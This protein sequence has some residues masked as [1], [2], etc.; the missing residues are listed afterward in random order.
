MKPAAVAGSGSGSTRRAFTLLELLVVIVIVAVLASL[1]MPAYSR[2]QR[3]AEAVAC[4]ANLREIG[5]GLNL[6]LGEHQMIMPDL[7]ALRSKTTDD[8]AVIDNTLDKYVQNKAVFAC[9][10]DHLGVA[11]ASGTSYYWNST[12]NKQ[13]VSSLAF[14][15]L[16]EDHSRIPVLN[17]KQGFHPYLD[18]KI[19]I[20]YADGHV[21][22]DL[23]FS[24]SK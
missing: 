8:V 1:L 11:A 6:Y 14:L 2:S 20:L 21:T 12:L 10:G 18:D 24:S 22:K 17:D 15:N 7:Q 3:G 19:N 5:V 9:P 23:K 4:T 13:S 16:T